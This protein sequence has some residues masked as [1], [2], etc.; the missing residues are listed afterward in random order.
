MFGALYPSKSKLIHKHIVK[1]IVRI[2]WKPSPE[3]GPTL[4]TIDET[5]SA[6][7]LLLVCFGLGVLSTQKSRRS[8]EE[9]IAAEVRKIVS[10]ANVDSKVE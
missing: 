10:T 1:H 3:S 8:R 9:N 4:K 7:P 5:V 2:S 6:P